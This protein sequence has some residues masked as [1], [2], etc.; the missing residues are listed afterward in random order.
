[1]TSTRVRYRE[2]QILRAS[3]LA[4]EQ[5]YRIAMRRRHNV[6][7]HGWG[8]VTGLAITHEQDELWLEPGM[9]VDGYG[10]ELIVPE[11]VLLPAED[12]LEPG[13][14]E[15]I[16]VWLHYCRVPETPPQQGRWECGPGEHSRWREEAVIRLEAAGEINPR[17]PPEVPEAD[18][19]FPPYRTPPDASD[20]PWP[21]YLGRVKYD[22]FFQEVDI[23]DLYKLEAKLQDKEDVNSQLLLGYLLKFRA[24]ELNDPYRLMGKLK[25][26]DRLARY[27][28]QKLVFFRAKDLQDS[29]ALANRLHAPAEP[30][31]PLLTD[32]LFVHLL[33]AMLPFQ[34]QDLKKPDDLFE[35]L[36][37]ESDVVSE[38]LLRKLLF[39]VGLEY[40]PDLEAGELSE[41]FRQ[42]FESHDITLSDDLTIET[43]VEGYKW[44]IKDN[45]TG[46]RFIVLKQDEALNIYEKRILP[47][48]TEDPGAVVLKVLN[49][50][51]DL[52]G[53]LYDENAF[54]GVTLRD[55]TQAYL[56]KDPQGVALKYLNR[57]LLEDAYGEDVIEP[58]GLFEY[59]ESDPLSSEQ[60]ESLSET[61]NRL[62]PGAS[63]YDEDAFKDVLI[64]DETLG[65]HGRAP[66]GSGLIFLN[67]LLLEDAF[68]DEISPLPP[69]FYD[70][71]QIRSAVLIKALA[72]ALN[73]RLLQG[74]S[75]YDPEAFKDKDD[76]LRQV[77]KDLL[78]LSSQLEGVELEYLN[79]L[80][81]KDAYPDEIRAFL[82]SD[83]PDPLPAKER[84]AWGLK[85][86]VERLNHL[87]LGPSLSDTAASADTRPVRLNR[88]F[89]E[90]VFKE[91]LASYQSRYVVN[92]MHRPYA[93]L[94]GER[95]MSPAPAGETEAPPASDGETE[96]TSASGGETGASPASPSQLRVGSQITP[97]GQYLAVEFAKKKGLTAPL[98]INQGGNT[99]LRGDVGLGRDLEGR[100]PQEFEPDH[101]VVATCEHNICVHEL[102]DASSLV[103]KLRRQDDD[104]SRYLYSQFDDE[105]KRL[106]EENDGFSPPSEALQQALVNALNQLLQDPNLYDEKRFQKVRLSAQI[107][108]RLD[109][110]PRGRELTYLNRVLLE[111]AYRWEIARYQHTTD[112]RWGV[113]FE[114]R[115]KPPEEAAPWQM[116]HTLVPQEEQPTFDQLRI[117]IGHPADKGNPSLH[118]LVIGHVDVYDQE[119]FTPC[120]TATA[121]C[122][123]F[124]HG[125]LGI[126]GPLVEGPIKPD[127]S[128]PR[129]GAAVLGSWLSG[130]TTGGAQVDAFY[131]GS[132]LRLEFTGEFPT[133]I[134][135]GSTWAYSFKISNLGED[136][137]S[138]IQVFE[139]LS[140]TGGT[141]SKQSITDAPSSLGP[142][143]ESE[144]IDVNHSPVVETTGE[145]TVIVSAIYF[146]ASNNSFQTSISGTATISPQDS[147]G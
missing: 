83:I 143:A 33:G 20:Q 47:E 81:L 88:L 98:A 65:L 28:F 21:V 17:C 3:D 121:D 30:S 114:A 63:L 37:D 24:K 129:F 51:I 41:A 61:L 126:E 94:V 23:I 103:E 36:S 72:E 89:L 100:T 13:E 59:E 1:M 40:Q 104:V 112:P 119:T 70:G 116:Y 125:N 71:Y 27:L 18:L 7:P 84:K 145:I 29:V 16:D 120:L 45:D 10:R 95:V 68:P 58:L 53:S 128:D 8:I 106:L 74:P 92:L 107:R 35:R 136:T 86:W 76:D 115:D 55:I 26:G 133:T 39:S 146:D 78:D 50:L 4:D 6:G 135:T 11:R 22:W 140:S 69:F 73:T 85:T 14:I 66:Q 130:L 131:S 56:E 97:D 108:D 91:A 102:K 138:G 44:Q 105:T 82:V 46:R 109:K 127:L 142:K 80:L 137:I 124:I 43:Q 90:E 57:L 38:H 31:D 111:G 123:V 54:S 96:T 147:V 99:T 134:Y 42:Q 62:L 144:P 75:I 12:L 110:N 141:A 77:T 60:L 139:S 87:L 93:W 15:A 64:R 49:D 2:G 113:E 79:R 25:A 101:L 19:A 34:I 117:E 122:N 132:A 52:E 5:A 48:E 32:P 9:A 67:R 118:R